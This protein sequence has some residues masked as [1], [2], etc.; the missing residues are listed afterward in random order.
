MSQE[1]FYTSAP[2]GLQPGARGFCTVAATRG[3]SPALVEKL[4]S[5]SG[6]RP[7][8][9]PHDARAGMN[10]VAFAHVRVS[11]GG[12]TYTVV[13]RIGPAGLDYTERPNKFAH[14]VV[15]DPAELPAGGPAWLLGQ[16]GFLE[17]HWDGQVQV[18]PAGR[19]APRG[20]VAPAVCR[21]WQALTGDAG[22]GGVLAEAFQA[23]PTRLVY[24]V[25]DPGMDLLPLFAESLALLP[26]EQRWEVTFSTYFTG[27]P[28]GAQC[29][30]RC[31]PRGSPEA[32]G[33]RQ[34]PGALI[35]DLGQELGTARGGPLVARACG[36]T[37]APPLE[38][39]GEPVSYGSVQ[40]AGHVGAA[41]PR[42][43]QEPVDA[44]SPHPAVAAPPEPVAATGALAAPPPL[45]PP[46]AP[47]RAGGARG[48][49]AGGML[50]LGVGL[51]AG[52]F[53][54]L[55][56]NNF[57]P[58]REENAKEEPKRKVE[59]VKADAVAPARVEPAVGRDQEKN[60][61]EA[62]RLWTEFL[63]VSRKILTR[64][65]EL[66]GSGR[67]I[68]NGLQR[69]L[70]KAAQEAKKPR[71][72]P[73]PGADPQTEIRELASQ[74][75]K[76]KDLAKLPD[77]VRQ[78]W[79]GLGSKL[80]GWVDQFDAARAEFITRPVRF[81]SRLPSPLRKEDRI[82]LP[83]A[84]KK[85]G[86]TDDWK[87]TLH[88]LNKDLTQEPK[89]RRLAVKKAGGDLAEFRLEGADLVFRWDDTGEQAVEWRSWVR[90]SVLEVK[91]GEARFLIGLNRLE[92]DPGVPHRFP[93]TQGVQQKLLLDRPKDDIPEKD[94]YLD[95]AVCELAG[96]IR[97]LRAF[98][99][100]KKLQWDSKVV[101][102]LEK[103]DNSRPPKF[104]MVAHWVGGEKD[105]ADLILHAFAAYTNVGGH[106][107]EVWR[108]WGKSR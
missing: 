74:T 1:L 73:K 39:N 71:E 96:Q 65:D 84:L 78:Q 24:L 19:A 69:L 11:A 59:A 88:G 86:N 80:Y 36:R 18:L 27:L 60:A 44:R 31:V 102:R 5:L 64:L 14:H 62:L 104:Q 52:I 17:A 49:L 81:Y 83:E 79:A 67:D 12:R 38:G 34:F 25:F 41:P 47:Q 32:K 103:L 30:W 91:A 50:G 33:A 10:P 106:P 77:K 58:P 22:W 55:G 43:G 53:I 2:R 51:V 94:V 98:P 45:L 107:V 16:P 105:K 90:N 72:A 37:A 35:L 101:L 9:P 8:F 87:L 100:E 15:L 66:V 48:W 63:Q 82:P 54:T 7:L 99:D 97:V 85:L 70:A 68:A 76:E 56:F 75:K 29:L 61:R 42:L 108:V 28:Q 4:E 6:Y 23:D 40:E 26:P 21:R 93:L 46:V 3:L 95:F 57:G 13:S 20:D 92:T 89:K